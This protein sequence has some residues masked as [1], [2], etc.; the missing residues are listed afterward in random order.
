MRPRPFQGTVSEAGEW[1]AGKP[2]PSCIGP[3][4]EFP[5][6]SRE[7]SL[8]LRQGVD[9]KNIFIKFENRLSA[10]SLRTILPL[11][12]PMQEPGF[13]D[14][15]FI[16]CEKRGRVSRRQNMDNDLNNPKNIK[17]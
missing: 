1:L 10:A 15:Y 17:L 5:V 13:A 4:G 2:A 9:K 14:M 8:D 6:L 12:D 7:R 3:G 11:F 16:P